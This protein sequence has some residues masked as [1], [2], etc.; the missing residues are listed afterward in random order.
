MSNKP[1]IGVIGLAVMG[2][3]LVLNIESR[4]RSVVVYNRTTRVAEEFV[5]KNSDK[6]ISVATTLEDLVAGLSA[7]RKVL[8]MVKAGQAVDSVIEELLGLLSPGD[9]IMDGGNSLYSDSD[10]RQK[11]CNRQGV[12][13]LGV[14]VSGG[15]EGALKGPSIMVGGDRAGWNLVQDLLKDISAKAPTPCVAY[16]GDGGAGHFVKMVHNG[17]EY[18]IMQLIAEACLLLQRSAGLGYPELSKLFHDW[19]EGELE[20]FLVEITA[21]VLEERDPEDTER[22]LVENILDVAGHKGT[23]KWTVEAAMNFGTPIPCIGAALDARILSGQA[24]AR[25]AFSRDLKLTKVENLAAVEVDTVRDALYAGMI[26]SFMQGLALIEEASQESGWSVNLAEVC[27]IWKGGC[28]IRARALNVLEQAFGQGDPALNNVLSN[29][30]LIEL[31][32]SKLPELRKAVIAG[33]AAATPIATFQQ[34]LSFVDTLATERLPLNII[35]AQR[36]LFGAHTFERRGKPGVA[37]HHN[38]PAIS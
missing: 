22:Y 37:L 17:I 12:L 16:M 24:H 38:W 6:Q 2:S 11:L 27:R 18:A 21:A 26:I 28:I 3:N 19:N 5:A 33:V 4:N 20:S 14:G 7:P 15:E 9:L 8:L 13:Y 23:G 29:P 10:R 25:A 32:G 30:A 35:Q 31:V 1:E 36:D 34:S